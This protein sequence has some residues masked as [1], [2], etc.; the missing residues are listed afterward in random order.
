VEQEVKVD[1]SAYL[2]ATLMKV[3]KKEKTKKEKDLLDGVMEIV[4]FPGLERSQAEGRL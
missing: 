1:R 3:M 2:E 4:I